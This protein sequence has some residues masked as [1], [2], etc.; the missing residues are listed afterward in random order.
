MGNKTETFLKIEGLKGGSAN[1]RHM[2]ETEIFGFTPH[3]ISSTNGTVE[4]KINK[5]GGPGTVA[6]YISDFSSYL[7]ALVT[8]HF[9]GSHIPGA[10][11]TIDVF[12]AKGRF[13]YFFKVEFADL[14]VRAY[15][16]VKGKRLTHCRLNFDRYE[17][18]DNFCGDL[19]PANQ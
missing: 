10:V 1:A 12:N 17:F 18:R 5:T 15:D 14:L 11:V 13:L 7:P 9:D 3:W 4:K 2:G 16:P 6:F 19:I 8:R